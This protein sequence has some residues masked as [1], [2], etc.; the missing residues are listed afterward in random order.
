MLVGNQDAAILAGKGVGQLETGFRLD[1]PD[2]VYDQSTAVHQASV[3]GEARRIFLLFIDIHF[4][5]KQELEGCTV[6]QLCLQHFK[7]IQ[8][9]TICQYIHFASFMQNLGQVL[10]QERIHI[11]NGLHYAGNP[12]LSRENGR[13]NTNHPTL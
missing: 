13:N 8:G 5:H 11:I 6:L 2:A 7:Q 9:K 1:P 10:Y 4:V 3:V 12:F